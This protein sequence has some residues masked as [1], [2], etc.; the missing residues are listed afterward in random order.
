M[1]K[2]VACL[3][4]PNQHAVE[5]ILSHFSKEFGACIVY[6]IVTHKHKAAFESAAL[7]FPNLKVQIRVARNPSGYPDY[8]DVD[9]LDE[10]LIKEIKQY[11]SV[12]GYVILS[13]GY[14]RMRYLP[15]WYV[16][17]LKQNY[18]LFALLRKIV[19]G[20][21]WTFTAEGVNKIAMDLTLRDFKDKH[22]GQR[23][24]VL[25]NGPS[26]KSAPIERLRNEVTFGSNRIYLGYPDW[27]FA[28]TYWTIVDSLQCE[29]YSF[30]WETNVP[31]E[32]PKFFPFEYASFF[33]F[34]AACP[35]NVYATGHPEN[36]T[37]FNPPIPKIDLIDT[38]NF[39]THPDYVFAGHNTVYIMIQLARIMGCDPIYLLGVDHNF[40]LPEKD[41]KR[42][43]WKDASSSSHFHPNYTASSG[44]KKEF[45][46]PNLDQATK[47]FD[48][49]S[50]NSDSLGMNVVNLTEGTALHSFKKAKLI[51]VL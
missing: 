17:P 42:G 25:G 21:V 26:L 12:D 37:N 10:S 36:P 13:K 9:L 2:I 44:I 38:P 51:D 29:K 19:N 8:Y 48:Y 35:I 11:D 27:G 4:H 43:I 41:E 28:C 22:K 18:N 14:T 1:S 6:A 24:F 30:E 32:S 49:A 39:S 40:A 16:P 23:C 45:H 33:N 34:D 15:E 7:Q 31:A 20:S 5:R 3:G 47:F 46:L 50:D